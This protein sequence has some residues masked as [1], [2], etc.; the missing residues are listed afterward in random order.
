MTRQQTMCMRH[1]GARRLLTQNTVGGLPEVIYDCLNHSRNR[2]RCG[3]S[4]N[5]F[6]PVHSSRARI[7][8]F[9]GKRLITCPETHNTEAID[10]AAKEAALTALFGEPTLRLDRC[11]RWPERQ[12]CGQEC[13]QQVETDPD[14]CLLWNIVSNW[15]ERQ[16][17][18]YCHKRFERL[19]HLD[20]PPA[21]MGPDRITAEWNQFR[22][23]QLPE[24][25]STFKPV[26]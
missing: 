10:V 5:P 20:H 25:L 19:Q 26:C 14:N 1:R 24:I 11:S 9:R 23:E 4:R 12:D 17:C 2:Y 6:F 16:H 13:L 7:F 3:S 18:V 22:P 15:Y 8:H 21:L